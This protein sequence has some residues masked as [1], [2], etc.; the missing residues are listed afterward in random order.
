MN[1]TRDSHW[2]CAALA[3]Y[4]LGF[5]L[6]WPR[7]LLIVDEDRY[8]SQ[9]VAFAQGIL[10]IPGRGILY[11]RVSTRSISDYPPGTA[12]L[13]APLV[14]IGGWRTAALLSV[15]G[16][17]V[18]TLA[19]MRWLRANAD[20]GGGGEGEGERGRRH[21]NAAF[22]LLL[23]GFVGAAFFGRVAMSDVPT[24]A[25]VAVTGVL[26]WKARPDRPLISLFAGLGA[27]LLLLFREPAMLLVLPLLV[28]AFVRG[29][30]AVWAT[31]AGFAAG[32]GIRL[33]AS[34]VLFGSPWY[35]RDP[36]IGF[37]LSSLR[38]TVP[39]YGIILLVLIPGGALL[40]LFY[41]GPR[42]AELTVAVVTYVALFLFYDYDSVQLN[43][44]V[45]GLMLASRFM[46]PALPLLALMAADVWRRWWQRVPLGRRFSHGSVTMAASTLVGLI[47][48]A[49]HPLA[50]SRETE[51]LVIRDALA[52][53]TRANIPVITNTDATLK[54][55]SPAYGARQLIVRRDLSRDSLV[56]FSR[57]FGLLSVAFLDRN[58]S[59]VFRADEREN[60]VF[61]AEAREACAVQ[62]TFVGAAGASRLRIYELTDCR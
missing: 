42:R 40:P 46:A 6:F 12:L 35:L 21:D 1:R 27:G 33:V 52:A 34:A 53:H 50:R 10:A 38:H 8:V 45:K 18:A 49:V 58:D 59:P 62:Q 3:A 47:G 28:G 19:T 57:R 15:I 13:Q 14:W 22:A 9:A 37:A 17:I 55:L 20:E 43:G 32:V 44:R 41:R 24:T 31:A 7:V 4:V 51:A 39:L 29:Q 54:Y 36:Q 60:T 30:C 26:V 61:L 23:P 11:P 56:S 2:V 5:V 16:L 25:L 48:F